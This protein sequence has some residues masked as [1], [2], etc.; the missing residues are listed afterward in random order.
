MKSKARPLMASE[1]LVSLGAWGWIA[2][3]LRATRITFALLLKVAR[4]AIGRP[5]RFDT[6][7]EYVVYQGMLD[8]QSNLDAVAIQNLLPSTTKT[9]RSVA[10]T[11]GIPHTE[12]R[13][14]DGTMAIR[15]GRAK[16]EKVIVIFHGGGYMGP[17]LPEQ[18]KVAWGFGDSL[19]GDT[20]VFILPYALA[21]ET[22]NHY[23]R[24]LQQ[25]VAL[26]DYLLDSQSV[27]PSTITLIG[28]SAGGHL[29]L[30]L[31][32]HL[33]HPNP[34]VSPRP[35]QGRLAGAA[36]ISPWVVNGSAGRSM[37]DNTDKDILSPAALEYWT[38]NYMGDSAPDYWNSLLTTPAE[39]WADLPVE[40]ILV[41][42][43]DDEV[44]RDGTAALCEVMQAGHK[45]T[46]AVKFPREL[47]THML[48]NRFLRINK[49]CASE[50][51]FLE[52]LS[53]CRPRRDR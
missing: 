41:V 49:P 27:Q 5:T 47:H 34:L 3:L 48:M 26:I 50:R 4:A 15:L 6:L 25:A 7:Y 22:G 8:F 13:L 1:Y 17:A 20:S 32:L 10:K 51:V 39:W 38:K 36:L 37:T 53:E 31:L 30:N 35:I 29:V 45:R 9:C 24:Q 40:D 43:G 19:P 42:Y 2:L 33:A 16:T 44:L 52:W 46:R 28:D 23:P 14:G 21:S 12:I 18:V 11:L